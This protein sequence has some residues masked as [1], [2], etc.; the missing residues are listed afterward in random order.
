MDRE[1]AT[2]L[3]NEARNNLGTSDPTIVRT[4]EKGGTLRWLVRFVAVTTAIAGCVAALTYFRFGS[5]WPA[6]AYLQGRSFYI[7]RPPSDLGVVQ[8]GNDINFQFTLYNMSFNDYNVVGTNADCTCVRTGSLPIRIPRWGKEEIP[9]RITPRSEGRAKH[10][11]GIYTD[12][13]SFVSAYA[14]VAYEYVSK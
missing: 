9:F 2:S 3:D 1:H 14:D 13:P 5:L 6:I 4:Q 11:V 7:Q 12:C 8:K 10:T